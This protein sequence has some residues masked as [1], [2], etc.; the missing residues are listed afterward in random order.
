MKPEQKTQQ[1]YYDKETFKREDIYKN[2]RTQQLAYYTKEQK[3]SFCLGSD[4]FWD[5]FND[6]EMKTLDVGCG[7]GELS[8][9]LLDRGFKNI[10][11]IDIEDVRCWDKAKE[12][13]E[14]KLCNVNFQ[15]MPYEDETFDVVTSIG[16]LEHLENPFYF[17]RE[18]SRVLKK[19]GKLVM[20]MPNHFNVYSRRKFLLEGEF[21]R[22]TITND[23]FTALTKSVFAK[24][25]YQYFNPEKEFFSAPHLKLLKYKKFLPRNKFFDKYFSANM[26]VILERLD[27]TNK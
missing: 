5:I 22:F 16:T 17:A 8:E 27:E 3:P 4:D 6:K 12:L 24:C 23:H 2:L 9:R 26:G 13:E 11:L 21:E 19:G 20:T 18:C 1:L 15:K 14:F 7:G 25:F 10:S